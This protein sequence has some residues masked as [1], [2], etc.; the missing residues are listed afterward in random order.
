MQEFFTNTIES[1]FIKNLLWKTPLPIYSTVID[2]SYILKNNIYV[3]KNHIIK[4]VNSGLLGDDG[5]YQILTSYD[6]GQYYLLFSDRYM[7]NCSYYDSETHKRLG[8]YL[9]CYRDIYGIDMMP[10]YNCV[11]NEFTTNIKLYDDH[12]SSRQNNDFKVFKIP[13]KLNQ[14]YTI[15]ID[16]P[17]KLIISSAFLRDNNLITHIGMTNQVD[18][19]DIAITSYNVCKSYINSRYT[20]PIVYEFNTTDSD[21]NINRLFETYKD[22]LYLLIQV[23]LSNTSSVTV[24]EGDYTNVSTPKIFDIDSIDELSDAELNNL[25]IS[26]L[27]LLQFND[28]IIH[29]YVPRLIEFLLGCVITEMDDITDNFKYIRDT[30]ISL[31]TANTKEAYLWDNK[32]RARIFNYIMKNKQ[33]KHLD[34][35]GLFDKDTEKLILTTGGGI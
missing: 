21:E 32:V 34:L 29:P 27:S 8:K 26:K 11:T 3:Y 31:Y 16:C 18:L 17:S 10:F 6:F 35:T 14:K 12:I 19:T 7:S 13:I 15:A 4:C 5:I 30:Y 9:R 25:L 22:Y 1:K 33:I 23:P 28:N 20:S 2:G 24:L